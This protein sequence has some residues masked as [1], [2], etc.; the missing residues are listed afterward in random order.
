ME[1]HMFLCLQVKK[2]HKSTK[3]CVSMYFL[4]LELSLTPHNK[5]TYILQIVISGGHSVNCGVH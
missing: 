3:T 5:L 1:T 4:H 2:L